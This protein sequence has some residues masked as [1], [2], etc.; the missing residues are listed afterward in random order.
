MLSKLNKML[1]NK[2]GFTL[3]ELI[4]VIAILGILAAIAVPKLGG[5]TK[6]AR[7]RAD[8]VTAHTIEN[9]IK[10][11]IANGGSF[12]DASNHDGKFSSVTGLEDI[13]GDVGKPQTGTGWNID[14]EGDD[15]TVTVNKSSN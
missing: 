13:L 6:S 12:S 14:V 10:M 9:G 1:R 5:F 7:N 3:I 11:H 4:V 2:K 15:I 8:E